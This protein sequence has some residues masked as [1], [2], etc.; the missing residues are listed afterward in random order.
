MLC[1]FANG[2]HVHL[3]YYMTLKMV[4]IF[5]N[6]GYRVRSAPATGSAKAR[7]RGRAT[8]SA[9]ATP[10]TAETPATGR[11]CLVLFEILYECCL[12]LTPMYYFWLNFV[13]KYKGSL[14]LPL[15]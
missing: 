4:L 5:I 11:S 2:N 7:G 13:A 12:A 3:A 10:A 14:N 15:L 8:A 1:C 9:P 6:C